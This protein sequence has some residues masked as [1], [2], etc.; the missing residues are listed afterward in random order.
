M[1]CRQHDMDRSQCIEMPAISEAPME[2]L[3]PVA[4]KWEGVKSRYNAH[5]AFLKYMA[6]TGLL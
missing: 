5:V 1:R 6:A 3:N 4:K 2:K